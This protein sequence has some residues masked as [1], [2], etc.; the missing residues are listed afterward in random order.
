VKKP[1]PDPA[2][3]SVVL[4]AKLDKD[5]AKK[6]EEAVGKV[7]GVDKK[8]TKVDDKKGEISVKIA[9]GEKAEKVTLTG[10]VSALKEAGVAAT[11]S[12]EGDKKEPEKP[13]K[14]KG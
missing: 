2:G 9:G 6:A 14:D 4:F 5:S 13:K 11:S 8:G 10:L 1:H 7:K 12:K 3:L